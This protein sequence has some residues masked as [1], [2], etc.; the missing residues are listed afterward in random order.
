MAEVLANAVVEIKLQYMYR[1]NQHVDLH[2]VKLTQG[3]VNYI[4]IKN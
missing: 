3:H 1:A 4:S 2:N